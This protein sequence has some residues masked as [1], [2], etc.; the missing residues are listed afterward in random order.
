MRI[1]PYP[2]YPGLFTANPPHPKLLQRHKKAHVTV[3]ARTVTTWQS[4]IAN[5]MK[6]C[7]EHSE[8]NA[9]EVATL[10]SQ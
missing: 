7:C 6:P 5:K 9:F 2:D 1:L 8:A 3:V 4:I 10:R